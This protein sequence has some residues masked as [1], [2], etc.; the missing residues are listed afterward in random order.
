MRNPCLISMFDIQ[1][2]MGSYYAY[3]AIL[4]F[5]FLVVEPVGSPLLLPSTVNGGH[6]VSF[7]VSFLQANKEAV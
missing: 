3:F 5:E 2:V 4:S 6:K 7:E 1:M